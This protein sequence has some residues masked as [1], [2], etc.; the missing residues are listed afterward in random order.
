METS[1]R[2]SLRG[3][4]YYGCYMAQPGFRA[5]RFGIAFAAQVLDAIPHGAYDLPVRILV[6]ERAALRFARSNV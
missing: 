1:R 6:T 2:S 5:T 4:G 3:G